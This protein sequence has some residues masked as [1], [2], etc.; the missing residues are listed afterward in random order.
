[1]EPGLWRKWGVYLRND[2]I[3][4]ELLGNGVCRQGRGAF[5]KELRRDVEQTLL[6]GLTR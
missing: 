5:R 2:P 6:I 1:M 3:E 4:G